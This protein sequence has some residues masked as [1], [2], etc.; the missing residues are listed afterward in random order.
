MQHCDTIREWND[1]PTAGFAFES[2][3]WPREPRIDSLVRKV[4]QFYSERI[5]T[6]L[7]RFSFASRSLLVRFSSARRTSRCIGFASYGVR[8]WLI[9]GKKNISRRV[10][11]STCLASAMLAKTRK[12]LDAR[13]P[14]LLPP[15]VSFRFFFFFFF[16]FNITVSAFLSD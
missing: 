11:R 4:S 3:E 5:T 14:P 2:R 15:V 16:Y 1:A 6:A 13:A 8:V 9:R 7:S 12:S 10:T